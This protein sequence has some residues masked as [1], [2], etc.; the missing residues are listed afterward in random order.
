MIAE[1][2]DPNARNREVWMAIDRYFGDPERERAEQFFPPD[3]F[4]HK[5]DMCLWFEHETE[6]QGPDG[7]QVR[8]NDINRIKAIVR[9]NNARIADTDAYSAIV[10]KHTK[11]NGERDPLPPRTIGFAG[12]YRIGMVGR[13]AP[14][15]ALFAD[16]HRRKD[17]AATFRDRPRRSVEVLTLRANGRSYIDPIAALSEAPRLPLPVQYEPGD[18]GIVE[19]YQ[20]DAVYADTDRYEG[21][22]AMPGGSN[23]YLPGGGFGAKKQ[24]FGA[25]SSYQSDDNP[26][27]GSMAL[28]PEDLNQIITALLS[29]PQMKFIEQM[30]Q[31]GG[32]MPGGDPNGGQ[33]GADPMGGQMP[34]AA[35]AAG[36]PSPGS[37]PPPTKEPY[38]APMLAAGAGMMA[39][40]AMANRFSADD[41]DLDREIPE[42]D[43]TE[44]YAALAES[45][46]KT[47]EE[48]AALRRMVAG[49]KM[50]EADATR[51]MRI[52]E[53]ASQYPHMV[54]ASEL[55]GRTLYS[56]GSTMSDDEFEDHLEIV[57]T[58]A[59]KA[60]GITT[61]TAMVPG[62]EMPDSVASQT[63]EQAQY[64]AALTDAM[65][66]IYTASIG[67][68]KPI[69]EAEAWAAAR[70]KVKK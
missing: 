3:Q 37:P 39:G 53:L 61:S 69:S 21:E 60:P 67:N 23:T 27:S 30:M 8:K 7:P 54:D 33:P 46:G 47:L 45:H 19:R 38:V 17:E 44:Q 22:A 25:E 18:H 66:E 65:V 63:V 52:S 56:A 40:Q 24:R 10:D 68:G 28:A 55:Q 5:R 58:Y 34:P 29:T 35:P 14:K 31:Q 70:E 64:E 1:L 48:L 32:Q 36:P 41:G 26:E 11:P 59:A 9:E 15:F 43:M 62:G 6:V 13:V 20:A 57:E 49:L 50:R 42:D 16:E 2:P 12:P 4:E 51:K